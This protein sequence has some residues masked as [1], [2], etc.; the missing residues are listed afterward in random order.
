MCEETSQNW[1]FTWVVFF[2][3]WNK[4]YAS[5][6]LRNTIFFRNYIC[7]KLKNIN[8]NSDIKK[9]V[10]SFRSRDFVSQ[11]KQLWQL[12]NLRLLNNP[13]IFSY[14]KQRADGMKEK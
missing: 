6:W 14:L 1:R 12:I 4:L 11:E 7:K 10:V 2:N 13:S 8:D 9:E 3:N 5:F